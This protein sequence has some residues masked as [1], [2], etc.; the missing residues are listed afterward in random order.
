MSFPPIEMAKHLRAS[1]HP[2]EVVDTRESQS[3]TK[4]GELKR[5]KKNARIW[6]RRRK[7]Q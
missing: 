6:Y 4:L 3:E 7:I 5:A 1:S 2:I